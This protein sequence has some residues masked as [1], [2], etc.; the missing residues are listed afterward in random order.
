MTLSSIRMF[1]TINFAVHSPGPHPEFN[2][3]GTLLA[4]INRTTVVRNCK[5]VSEQSALMMVYREII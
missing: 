2:P 4:R 3:I 5:L 1:L